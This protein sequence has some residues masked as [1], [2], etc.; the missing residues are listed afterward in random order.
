MSFPNEQQQQDPY[1]V[2]GVSKNATLQEIR[3]AYRKLALKHH[4]DRQTSEEAKRAA[5]PKFASISHAYEILSDPSARREYDAQQMYSRSSFPST[6]HYEFHDPFAVFAHVFGQEFGGARASG[7]SFGSSFGSA[8][9]SFFSDPFFDDARGHDSIFGGGGSLFGGSIFGAHDDVFGQMHRQM[10]MMQQQAQQQQQNGNHSSSYY[11]SSSSSTFGGGN[12]T[13]ES[14]T[15]T[16]RMI[17][18]KR[19]TVTERTIHKADGTVERHTETSGDDDFSTLEHHS[20][21]H[22]QLPA[23]SNDA[24]QTSNTHEHQSPWKKMKRRL[25]GDKSEK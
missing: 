8:R 21:Q 12:H 16:T 5:N 17:N 19:Q 22:A 18:G 1:Q 23:P 15:T 10:E 14:V 7:S 9:D 25:T 3:A 2:L 24:E 11:Y 20:Q 13:G 4:P 6:H